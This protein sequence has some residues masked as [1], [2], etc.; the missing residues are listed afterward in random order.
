MLIGEGELLQRQVEQVATAV[1]ESDDLDAT[2]RQQ[3]NDLGIIA[4]S[5]IDRGG[6]IVAS[7]SS[8]LVGDRIRDAFFVEARREARFAA[9]TVPA[10]K[11]LLLDGVLYRA[12]GEPLYLAE[13]P[14]GSGSVVLYDDVEKMLERRS[15]ASGIQPETVEQMA[16]AVLLFAG[17]AV[18]LVVTRRLR[19]RI[20]E[21]ERERSATD[22]RQRELERYNNELSIA[23]H[24]AERALALAAET[25]RIRSEFV[26]MINHE[27]RT[28]L[29]GVLTTAELLGTENA[30]SPAERDEFLG[31]L[32]GQAR[33]LDQ[34][35]SQML[36]VAR[37]ENRGLW[38]ELK[39]TAPAELLSA[40]GQVT[41]D[42]G[43]IDCRLLTDPQALATIIDILV[44]NAREHGASNV[45]VRA[46]CDAGFTPMT[47]IGHLPP[48]PIFI[49]IEDDGPGIDLEFVPSMFDKFTKKARKSG[50]GLGLYMARI[51]AEAIEAAILVDTGP[52]G[53]KFAVAV[54]TA[55]AKDFAA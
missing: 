25:N 13:A 16:V 29:T 14:A 8:T 39:P 38:F 48:D 20:E 12:P 43:S 10:P 27:L 9:A 30:M 36:A 42:D 24:E 19:S 55:S 52:D 41:F 51:I 22:E 53:S 33:R 40:L 54:R 44:T 50:T 47:S 4:I 3:R 21:W 45:T 2:L 5:Y 37:V 1:T 26:L 49:L 34:L 23:R 17:A 18:L 46:A 32:T 11:P 31:Y 28:P 35:I 6:T 15:R 7:T